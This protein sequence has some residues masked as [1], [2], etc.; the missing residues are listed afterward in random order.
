MDK[1]YVKTENGEVPIERSQA[2][3]YDLKAGSVSP[4]NRYVVA[5]ENGNDKAEKHRKKRNFSHD[6]LMSDGIVFTT[7]EVID[8]ARGADSEDTGNLTPE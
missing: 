8:L 3:K 7:S 4:C 2:E 6:E 1:L 5:D